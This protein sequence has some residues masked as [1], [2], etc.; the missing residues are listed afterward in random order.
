[1][2]HFMLRK[3][4][5][6]SRVLSMFVSL[7][8][9][10][11]LFIGFCIPE[12]VQAAS[13]KTEEVSASE[14]KKIEK[15]LDNYISRYLNQCCASLTENDSVLEMNPEYFEFNKK[16]KTDMAIMASDPYSSFEYVQVAYMDPLWQK[17]RPYGGLWVCSKSAK[18][19]IRETGKK[20]FGNSFKLV[21]AQNNTNAYAHDHYFY[22]FPISTDK[23]YI[24]NNDTDWGD[25]EVKHKYL[26]VNKKNGTYL[27]KAKYTYGYWYEPA[28]EIHSNVFTIKLKKKGSSYIITDI[29]C[30]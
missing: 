8:V 27:V 23:K 3:T 13:N 19:M 9:M 2:G 14:E 21:F 24:V 10:G 29:K 5:A 7:T 16:R 30:S 11:I 18:N 25:W 28:K 20:L 17:H 15:F 26:S 6:Y 1:M 12:K 22:F 4:C